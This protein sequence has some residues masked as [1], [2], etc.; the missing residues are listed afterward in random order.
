MK[1]IRFCQDLINFVERGARP[2]FWEESGHWDEEEE[3]KEEEKLERREKEEKK[4]KE[5]L[6]P[7]NDS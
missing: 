3:E 4:G 2:L 5:E 1:H 7:E 6:D